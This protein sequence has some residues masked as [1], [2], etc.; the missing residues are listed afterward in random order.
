[1]QETDFIVFFTLRSLWWMF[2]LFKFKLFFLSAWWSLMDELVRLEETAR[3]CKR[4]KLWEYRTNVVFGVGN[5]R[6]RLM[7]IGEGPGYN[8]DIKG[9]PFVG[10]AGNLL[11]R[12][13]YEETGLTR[14]ELYITNVVKCRPPNNRNPEPDEIIACNPYLLEQIKIIKPEVICTLGNFATQTVLGKK[15]GITKLRGR[16]FSAFGAVVIPTYHPA[17]IL[18]NMSLLEVFRADIRLCH[19]YLSDSIKKNSTEKDVE[20]RFEQ[21]T[22]F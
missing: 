17:A 19:K 8:E 13:V 11:D 4:C 6:A 21:P 20:K 1:M 2:Q 3:N 22:L 15:E 10:A 12:I 16:L 7:L 14:G 9:E 18:R 5:P